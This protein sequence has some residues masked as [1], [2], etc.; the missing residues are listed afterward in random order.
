M[1]TDLYLQII[2]PELVFN[3]WHRNDLRWMPFDNRGN[4][5]WSIMNLLLPAWGRQ[6]TQCGIKTFFIDLAVRCVK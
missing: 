2:D 1:E 4:R 3:R 5:N 6:I